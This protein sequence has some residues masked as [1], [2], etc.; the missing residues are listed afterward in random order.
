MRLPIIDTTR[1]YSVVSDV[2]W[3][4]DGDIMVWFVLEQCPINGPYAFSFHDTREGA[5]E[6]LNSLFETA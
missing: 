5:V 1:T 3:T 6:E 4:D 2:I